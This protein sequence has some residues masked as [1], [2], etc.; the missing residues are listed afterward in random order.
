MTRDAAEVLHDA[1]RALAPAGGANRLVP[2]IA[3]GTAPRDVLAALALEQRHIIDSDR[4]SFRHLAQRAAPEPAVAA[5][6]TALAEHETVALDRLAA[7]TA[8][9]GLDESAIETYEPRAGCQAYPSYVARLALL[10]EPADTVIALAVNFASWGGYCA[11]VSRALRRHYGFDD[12]ACGFFDLFAEP[13][14]DAQ[15]RTRA[16]V[17]AG[18]DAGRVTGAARRHGRLVQSYELMFWNTL[19]G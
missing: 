16:A 6:F 18:L 15:E 14:P 9:C 4:R 2:L 11:T 1:V 17:Q 8:A 13:A 12:A 5:F 7:L 19:A 3:A 10:A